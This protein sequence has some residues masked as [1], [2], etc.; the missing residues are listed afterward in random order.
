MRIESEAVEIDVARD[1]VYASIPPTDR[2]A[3][4]HAL[5]FG[6]PDADPS[7]LTALHKF[8]GSYDARGVR[9]TLLAGSVANGLS[10]GG[11]P[12]SLFPG[13]PAYP[14][15]PMKLDAFVEFHRAYLA[16]TQARVKRNLTA[17]TVALVGIS[18]SPRSASLITA[19]YGVQS[20][21]TDPT[22]SDPFPIPDTHHDR[23]T[24]SAFIMPVRVSG[25]ANS[26]RRAEGGRRPRAPQE[27]PGPTRKDT[28]V[29]AAAFF[30][31]PGRVADLR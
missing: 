2:H 12:Q 24:L 6:L 15:R 26:R 14:P 20:E 11:V 7:F 18:Q 28:K 29:R 4:L 21:S 10:T 31:R 16:E 23:L 17:S 13:A 8:Y 3:S 22:P 30:S 5:Q 1:V 9:L 19:L 27:T 25:G